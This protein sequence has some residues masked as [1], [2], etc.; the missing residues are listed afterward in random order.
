MRPEAAAKSSSFG[1][2]R[3]KLPW[4][5]APKPAPSSPPSHVA[6][7]APSPPDASSATK[8]DFAIQLRWAIAQ[9]ELGIKRP[10]CDRGQ[11]RE[12][13]R[14][15]K[16]LRSPRLRLVQKRALLKNFFGDYRRLMEQHPVDA[17]TLEAIELPERLFAPEPSRGS[18]APGGK[19]RK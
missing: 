8:V 14:L 10:D 13:R 15:I 6:E 7:S 12:S 19:R 4:S 3:E 5:D 9:L 17:E 11:E 18:A 16:S 1:T 2:R